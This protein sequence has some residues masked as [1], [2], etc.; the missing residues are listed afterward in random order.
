MKVIIMTQVSR[1]LITRKTEE[2]ILNLFISAV[3]LVQNPKSAVSFIDDLLTP[4]EKVMLS[5][6]FSIAFMLLEGYDY[7]QIQSA[8][9]VSSATVGRVALWLKTKGTGV[10]EVRSKI[11][12]NESLKAIWDDIKDSFSELFLTSYGTNWKAGNQL[13][14]QRKFEREKPF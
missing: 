14:R 5:K 1:R 10:R 6:R 3:V 8:L 11:K 4:T 12:N 2:R 7:N 9:K 13:L